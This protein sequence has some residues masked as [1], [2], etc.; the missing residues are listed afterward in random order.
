[1]YDYQTSDLIFEKVLDSD[2]TIT[3]DP[4]VAF[5]EQNGNFY[6]QT[7]LMSLSRTYHKTDDY[8][9]TELIKQFTDVL[10]NYSI[11]ESDDILTTL[12]TQKDNPRLLI[13]LKNKIDGFTDKSPATTM[14]RLYSQ[15]QS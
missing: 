15:I 4:V 8:G 3:R 11:D 12:D 13:I 9:H 2:R 7:P 6:Y 14:G 10:Q 1:M 5:L